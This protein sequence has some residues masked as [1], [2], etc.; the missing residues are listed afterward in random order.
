MISMISLPYLWLGIGCQQGA[1]GEL[2]ES[3]IRQ[4]LALSDL[5][6]VDVVGVASIDLKAQEPGILEVCA[7]YNWQFQT[8][9]AAELNNVQIQQ[10]STTVAQL[11]G[12]NSVAEAAAILA[13]GQELLV[14]K[15]IYSIGGKFITV[16]IAH[17]DIDQHQSLAPKVIAPKNPTNGV[18]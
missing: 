13:S 17:F 7:K 11:V 4:T 2:I 14:K 3:A 9:S 10:P 5:Q 12:T 15:Q 8:Y 18:S 6:I 16:A 1:S